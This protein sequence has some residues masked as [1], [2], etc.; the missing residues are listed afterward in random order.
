MFKY[1]FIIPHKNCPDLLQRC[2]DSIPERDDVQ[3]IVVDDKSDEGKKPAL[4]HRKNLQVIFLDVSQSKGAGRARNVG[5]EHAKG[6]WLLFADADDYYVEGFINILDHYIDGYNDVVYF[7]FVHRDGV[8]GNDMYNLD[9]QKYVS[10]YDG[11]KESVDQ[12]KFHINNP[13]VKMVSHAY[14][15]KYRI[16]FEEVPNGNDILFSMKVGYYTQ[17]ILVEKK[18]LYVYLRNK[19]SILTSKETVEAALCR[20][21]HLVKLNY[22]YSFIGHP[23]WKR[24]VRKIVTS[25]IVSLKIPFVIALCKNYIRILDE[26]NEWVIILSQKTKYLD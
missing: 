9:F 2:V 21:T 10:E 3:V 1:S 25:K 8:S 20:L 22:F 16:R 11:S 13:W 4:K 24:S 17:N 12:I 18:A 14:I 5:L 6:K 26:R 15:S 19:N 7:G 23:E